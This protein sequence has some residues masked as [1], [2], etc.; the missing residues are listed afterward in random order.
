[1]KETTKHYL[2]HKRAIKSLGSVSNS[3]HDL[4]GPRYTSDNVQGRIGKLYGTRKPLSPKYIIT[5]LKIAF[6]LSQKI[7]DK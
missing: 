7:L 4:C 3:T 1:M 5:K 2:H 6:G